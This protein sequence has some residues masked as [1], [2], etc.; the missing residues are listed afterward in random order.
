[1]ERLIIEG[2]ERLRGEV[3]VHGAKNSSL[4][5]LAATLLYG[6]QTILKNCPNLSEVDAAIKIL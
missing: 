4:P 2:G 1:M 5:I 3:A 6:G